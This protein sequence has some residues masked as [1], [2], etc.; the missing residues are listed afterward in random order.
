MG[1]TPSSLKL[2]A[3]DHKIRLTKSGFKTWERTMTVSE[4]AVER[5][6]ASLDK[7]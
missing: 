1:S 4:G 6:D 7:E 2:T 5:I 3:G